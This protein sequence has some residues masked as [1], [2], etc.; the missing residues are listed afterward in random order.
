[1][2][3]DWLDFYRNVK[4]VLNGTE[5][6]VI[7]IFEVRRVLAVMEAA[8]KSAETGLAVEFE[9]AGEETGY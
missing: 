5:E 8:R 4:G 7:K 1:M 2:K 6:S 3:T 9:E